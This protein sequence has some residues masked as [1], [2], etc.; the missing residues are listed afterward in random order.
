MSC[1]ILVAGTVEESISVLADSLR[2][3][4]PDAVVQSSLLPDPAGSP[5]PPDPYDAV[6][7]RADRFEELAQV[8]LLR[9][10]MGGVP[11]L[12]VSQ[13][14]SPD[15]RD[16]AVEFGATSFL[17][18]ARGVSAIAQNIKLILS[19]STAQEAHL[20][21]MARARRLRF[22]ISG[23][24][25]ENQ[26]IA[27]AGSPPLKRPRTSGFLPL[28][29]EDDPNQAFRMIC[30]LEKADV[31]APLPIVRTSEDAILYLQ[32][33]PPFENRHRYP[34]P[35]AVFLSLHLRE[36]SGHE[37]LGWIRRQRRFEWMPVILVSESAELRDLTSAY[38]N[39]PNF[40]LVKSEGFDELADVIRDIDRYGSSMNGAE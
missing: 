38:G 35:S 22:E 31:F 33:K 30:A 18:S 5:L 28:V 34:L 4:L 21:H 20:D 27:D 26:A 23:L 3:H 13:E 6:V 15:F 36:K 12:L 40:Y 16:H 37:L 11:I 29:V 14:E 25:L 8:R 39:Q 9:G 19:L 17:P 7:I 24:V 1:R 32:G 2:A 10:S